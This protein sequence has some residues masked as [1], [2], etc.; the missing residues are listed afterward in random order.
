M[1][2]GEVESR[3]MG[4]Y[5]SRV[6]K[7]QRVEC[8]SVDRV[9]EVRV[10]GVDIDGQEVFEGKESPKVTEFVLITLPKCQET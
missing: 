8:S 10:G 7:A 3:K 2:W 1:T 5:V 4:V 9:E 6:G